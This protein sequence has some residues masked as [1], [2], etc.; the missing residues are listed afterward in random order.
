MSL[1]KLGDVTA[2]TITS[3]DLDK[4]FEYWQKLGFAEV[5]RSD[6][7]FPWVQVTDGA[8]LIMLRKDATPY[9]ALTYYVN[10]EG[11]VP[12]LESEGLVFNGK[13]KATDMVKRYVLQS[14]D[15]LNISLVMAP[16][17]FTQPPGPT[18]LTMP[19]TD[20]FNPEKYV[21]KVCGMFGEFAHPVKNLET[22][23]TFWEKLG[24]KAISK[25]THPYP[26]AIISDG[27]AIVGLHQTDNFSYPAITYFAADMK[28][29]IAAL[30]QQ[31]LENYTD[32]GAG[33]IVLTTPE[34]QHV[35]LFKMGF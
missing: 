23:I 9:C 17:G 11:I 6:F 5:M 19:Q 26:W 29:K 13:P 3:P 2:I 30:K 28:E 20:F 24:F 18:M 22:S 8:L 21:N 15:G 32:K 16:G 31:G 14:P 34:N 10:D 12:L 25:F 7:P 27:L 1:P 33:S 4:S 35:N